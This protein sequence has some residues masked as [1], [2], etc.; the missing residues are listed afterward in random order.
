M[1]L[2]PGNIY[3]FE[4]RAVD[5]SG[6]IVAQWP[7]TP[8]WTAWPGR[9]SEPPLHDSKTESPI[10]HDIWWR[11]QFPGHLDTDMTD[12][13]PLDRFLQEHPNAFEC[14]YVRVGKAWQAWCQGRN[15]EARGQLEQLVRELPA[16]NVARGTAAALLRQLTAGQPFPK[17]LEFVP[18][19]ASGGDSTKVKTVQ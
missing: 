19:E 11:G 5:G 8:V 12:D 9:E 10:F 3:K 7:A 4:V 2:E 13:E 15:D 14:D 6:K 18:D 17:N 16:G 1:R